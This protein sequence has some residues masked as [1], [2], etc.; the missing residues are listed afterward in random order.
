MA[1]GVEVSGLTSAG[2]G[3]LGGIISAAIALL[4]GLRQ[5]RVGLQ[6]VKE[7]KRQVDD[8]IENR[9]VESRIEIQCLLADIIRTEELTQEPAGAEKFTLEDLMDVLE[10]SDLRKIADARGV[11]ER[12]KTILPKELSHALV[13]LQTQAKDLQTEAKYLQTRGMIG[14]DPIAEQELA[15]LQEPISQ[16]NVSCSNVIKL[17]ESIPELQSGK[18][19]AP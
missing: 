6:Q 13:A 18:E 4:V 8:I 17:L 15:H 16:L 12:S 9:K 7:M 2:L 11:I 19:N 10:V 3:F 14:K 5:I 1:E